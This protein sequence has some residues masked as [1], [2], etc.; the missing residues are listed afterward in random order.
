MYSAKR[1]LGMFLALSAV[2]SCVEVLIIS[3]GLIDAIDS[4][5]LRR[6]RT[7]DL[8]NRSKGRQARISVMVYGVTTDIPRRL[9]QDLVSVF[10]ESRAFITLKTVNFP[11]DRGMT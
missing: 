7:Y 9:P 11:D 3:M 4:R 1:A 2:F 5:A 8:K 6:G 10:I